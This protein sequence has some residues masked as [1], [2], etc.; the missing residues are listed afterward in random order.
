MIEMGRVIVIGFGIMI[1][2]MVLV[3]SIL[4]MIPF[5]KRIEFDNLCYQYSS[6]MLRSGEIDESERVQMSNDLDLLGFQNSSCTYP[7]IIDDCFIIKV[8][9]YYPMKYIAQDFT[10]KE[11]MLPLSFNISSLARVETYYH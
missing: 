3:Q 10:T 7:D 5:I 8:R 4:L 2:T 6:R 1:M 9:A 11:L